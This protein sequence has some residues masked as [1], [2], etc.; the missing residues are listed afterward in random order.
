M[1]KATIWAGFGIILGAAAALGHGD[2]APQSVDTTGLP[3][4]PEEDGERESLARGRSNGA[5]QGG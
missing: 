3:E 1:R 5:V 2:T 4:L